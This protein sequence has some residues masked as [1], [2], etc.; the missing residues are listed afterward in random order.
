M[1]PRIL[2]VTSRGMDRG[3][4]GELIFEQEIKVL[5]F[6]TYQG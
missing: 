1:I 2:K 4:R 5:I 6:L 3:F